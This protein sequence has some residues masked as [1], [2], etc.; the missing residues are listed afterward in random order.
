MYPNYVKTMA[1]QQPVLMAQLMHNNPSPSSRLSRE[2]TEGKPFWRNRQTAFLDS[3]SRDSM[4]DFCRGNISSSFVKCI[5]RR[6]TSLWTWL[7]NF[8]SPAFFIL[9]SFFH[10]HI[11]IF[12]CRRGRKLFNGAY[13]GDI[14]GRKSRTAAQVWRCGEAAWNFI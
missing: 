5:R 10:I 3:R 4:P 12:R 13:M 14:A 2:L 1:A 9:F 6:V 11:Y 7:K 8:F